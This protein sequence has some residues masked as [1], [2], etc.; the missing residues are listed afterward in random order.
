MSEITVCEQQ[1]LSPVLFSEDVVIESRP[2]PPSEKRLRVDKSG[3]QQDGFITVERKR[4]RA[5]PNAPGMSTSDE[6]IIPETGADYAVYLTSKQIL[7]KQ[8]G[9]AKFLRTYGISN[10]Q[11]IQFRSMYKVKLSFKNK[12]DAEKLLQCEV[13]KELDYRCQSADA[14]SLSYGV[15]RGADL[16]LSEEEMFAEF[17]CDAEII[18]IRRLK[19]LLDG[20][21]VDSTVIRIG[22]KSPSLPQYI[23]GYGTRFKIEQYIFPVTQCS[24]CWKFGHL[25]RACPLK[26]VKCPKCGGD[27]SNCES[28]NFI[29][30]NCKG[31]HMSL[32][33]GCPIFLKEK[34]IRVIMAQENCTYKNALELFM[35]SQTQTNNPGQR[36]KESYNSTI[37]EIQRQRPT[38]D[39]TNQITYRDAVLG[40]TTAKNN[41][42]RMFAAE[43]S[44]SDSE[45]VNQPHC[46][47]ASFKVK[48]PRF[49]KKTRMGGQHQDRAQPIDNTKSPNGDMNEKE[50][51]RLPLLQRLFLKIKEIMLE[52]GSF[53]IKFHAVIKVLMV[54]ISTAVM[55]GFRNSDLVLGVFNYFTSLFNG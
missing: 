46:S 18:S 49:R 40:K 17:K 41:S 55:E 22:F 48:K 10:I 2:R 15:I 9:L 23:M 31:P 6:E 16:N 32:D 19:R 37:G 13:L 54:E 38:R 52:K 3:E 29:C 44:Q 20:Q 7:P 27:H 8:M 14:V 51:D 25:V 36:D 12:E 24:G 11:K 34:E 33:K 45:N 43:T 30:L 21:W 28:T 5:L 4:K 26:R 35:R 42:G 47:G 50:A 39:D 53:Q 1:L